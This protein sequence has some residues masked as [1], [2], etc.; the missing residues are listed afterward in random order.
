M[1][2]GGDVDCAATSGRRQGM[3][4]SMLCVERGRLQRLLAAAAADAGMVNRTNRYLTFDYCVVSRGVGSSVLC[5]PGRLLKWG[6]MVGT[7]INPPSRHHPRALSRDRPQ[8]LQSGSVIGRSSR[9]L[10]KYYFFIYFLSW[11]SSNSS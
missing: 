9:C 7:Y 11:A 2:W 3:R 1:D 6:H 4:T 10:S 5:L 8:V